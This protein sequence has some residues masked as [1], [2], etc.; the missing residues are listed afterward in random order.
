MS[1]IRYDDSVPI[2]GVSKL[3]K[4]A[5]HELSLFVQGNAY[6]DPKIS[7]V[8]ISQIVSIAAEYSWPSRQ[9]M[10]IA[11]MQYLLSI[12]RIAA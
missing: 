3:P 7:K 2:C 8:P 11:K 4:Q 9:E 5:A 12:F 1:I 6:F 10:P